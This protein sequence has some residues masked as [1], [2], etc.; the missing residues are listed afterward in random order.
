MMAN[1]SLVTRM[2]H[3]VLLLA[4]AHQLILVGLV[5]RP[6]V[7]FAGNAFFAWHESVG[8]V[9]VGIV[10]AFWLWTLLRQSETAPSALFPWL[11][12]RRRQALWLDVRAHLNALRRFRLMHADESPLAGAAHGLGLLAVFA[13]AGTGAVMAFAKVPGGVVLQIHKLMANLIWAYV[14][15]HAGM[16][17]LHQAQGDDVW[18]RMFWPRAPARRAPCPQSS[19]H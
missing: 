12:T 6:K 18:Q 15:A 17:L 9:T 19:R 4:V 7:G 1:R 8:L 11:S 10:V 13:M 2:L 16:A 5:E 14:I 3:A